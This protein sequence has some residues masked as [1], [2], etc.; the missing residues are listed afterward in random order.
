MD[1]ALQ[2]FSVRG[3]SAVRLSDI[4]TDAGVTRGAVY[5]HFGSKKGLLLAIL[6]EFASSSFQ[7]TMEVLESDLEPILK[8]REMIRRMISATEESEVPLAHRRL[9]MRFMAETPGGFEDVHKAISDEMRSLTRLLT[10]VIREGQSAG[11]IR[12]DVDAR[13]ING[14][15]GAILRGSAILEG[16]R[17]PGSIPRG[18]SNKV[19]DLVIKGLE[20]R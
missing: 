17:Y 3:Y 12:S 9:A 7:V 4:A 19:A 11:E 18:T 8:I 1:V 6:R 14:T 16:R 20:P 2:A 15:I 13:V 10:R 5:W